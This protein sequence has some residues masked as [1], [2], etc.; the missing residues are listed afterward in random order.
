LRIAETIDIGG[1]NGVSDSKSI[2]AGW[3]NPLKA[4]TGGSVEILNI[5]QASRHVR[6]HTSNTSERCGSSTLTSDI[7]GLHRDGV[8]LSVGKASEGILPVGELR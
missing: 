4:K 1:Q 5:L 6:S 8:S 7:D 3:G 2:V